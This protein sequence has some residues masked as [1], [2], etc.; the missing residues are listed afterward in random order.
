MGVAL[1]GGAG[2][3]ESLLHTE[4]TMNLL[5]RSK[6]ISVPDLWHSHSGDGEVLLSLS[7]LK[8]L[9]HKLGVCPDPWLEAITGDRIWQRHQ[10]RG[11][12]KS[13]MKYRI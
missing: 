4:V 11:W 5:G 1:R 9:H 7:Y 10:Q 12:K 2:T 13:G 8:V 3:E 6:A